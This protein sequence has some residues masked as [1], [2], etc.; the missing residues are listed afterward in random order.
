MPYEATLHV[1]V[2]ILNACTCC[3][4]NSHEVIDSPVRCEWSR[5][6]VTHYT[7]QFDVYSLGVVLRHVAIDGRVCAPTDALAAV[8]TIATPAADIRRLLL[9]QRL[10]LLS[11]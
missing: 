5:R 4:T 2:H 9:D 7:H 1:N 3:A 11:V 8:L 6:D 10:V